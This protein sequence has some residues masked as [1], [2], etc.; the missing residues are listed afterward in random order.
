MST[1]HPATSALSLHDLRARVKRAPFHQW[2]DLDIHA[3]DEE[4]VT[5]IMRWREEMV[6]HPERRYTHG[7]ILSAL[8]DIAADYAIAAKIGRAVPTID[9]RVDFH[10][11]ASP[12]DLSATGRVVS[13]GRTVSVAQAEVRDATGVLLATGRGVFFT[14]EPAA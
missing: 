14:A 5:I 6:A 7:G 12:G 2:L 4:S 13:L 10:R 9:L 1:G 8:C 11:P 3:M